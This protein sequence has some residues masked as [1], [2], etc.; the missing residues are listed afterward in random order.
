MPDQYVKKRISTC[1]SVDH[2][3]DYQDEATIL[4]KVITIRRLA[5]QPPLLCEISRRDPATNAKLQVRG[6]VLDYIAKT[7]RYLVEETSK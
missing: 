1:I 4:S 5:N 6:R 7:G 3:D 2:Y